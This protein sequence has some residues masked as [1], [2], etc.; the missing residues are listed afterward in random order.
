MSAA[1]GCS[2]EMRCG[3]ADS[4]GCPVVVKLEALSTFAVQDLRVRDRTTALALMGIGLGPNVFASSW[5][6]R[7]YFGGLTSGRYNISRPLL[8][9]TSCK[10][11]TMVQ[12]PGSSQHHQLVGGVAGVTFVGEW[13]RGEGMG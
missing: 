10:L 1:Q 6:Y 7:Y 11:H 5:S 9:L 12:V 8:S 3:I 2:F 13:G 4:P